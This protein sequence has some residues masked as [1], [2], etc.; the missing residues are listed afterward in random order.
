[1]KIAVLSDIHGNLAALRTVLEDV[2]RQ[3]VDLTVNL[4][5]ILSGPLYPAETADLLMPLKLPTIQGNHERQLLTQAEPSMGA[6][7]RYAHQCLGHAHLLWLES[8]P[9]EIVVQG[10]VLLTHGAPGD[11]LQ[12]LLETVDK[13][14]VRPATEAEVI[15]RLGDVSQSLILCGHTHIPRACRLTDGRMIVNPGSVGLQ[16]YDDDRPLPHVMQTGSP[17]A[18][19]AIVERRGLDWVVELRKVPYDFAA[20]AEQ[21][22]RQGQL[23]WAA[24]LRT[25]RLG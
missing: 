18:S 1:M 22:C 8:L 21:A 13:N 14:G 11:D 6:S 17:D 20:V 23:D 19:Y 3:G 10:D 4:G 15:G 9:T 5:D 25:G 7:D 16:A 2:N 12:Y 24:A